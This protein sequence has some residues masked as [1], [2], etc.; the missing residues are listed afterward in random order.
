LTVGVSEINSRKRCMCVDVF[1]L[2]HNVLCEQAW[3][4][5]IQNWCEASVLVQD[6]GT[7]SIDNQLFHC[8]VCAALPKFCT[9]VSFLY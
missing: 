4:H 5:S 6:C 7:W 2:C 3:A 9:G 8:L 1:S